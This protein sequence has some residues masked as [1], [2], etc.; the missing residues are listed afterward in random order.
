MT[1][2][3]ALVTKVGDRYVAES[4]DPPARLEAELLE[5]AVAAL[6]QEVRSRTDDPNDLYLLVS[7]YFG[8]IATID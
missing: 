2:V 3:Q 7:L 8:P 6:E 5:A 1:V 4:T